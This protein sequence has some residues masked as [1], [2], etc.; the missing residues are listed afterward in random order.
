MKGKIYYRNDVGAWEWICEHGIGH[1]VY[2][3]VHGC[4]GCCSKLS[5]EE[6][7]EIDIAIQDKIREGSSNG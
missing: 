4:D 1:Y 7:I 6:Y 5:E 3:G 2:G